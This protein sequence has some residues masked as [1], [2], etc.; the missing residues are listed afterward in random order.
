MIGKILLGPSE[1]RP[2]ANALW[3]TLFRAQLKRL[4]QKF[5]E[6]HLLKEVCKYS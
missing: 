3:D 4:Q 1:K 2:Y 6:V 5:G